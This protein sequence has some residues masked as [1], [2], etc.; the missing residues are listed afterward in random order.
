[1]T[2]VYTVKLIAI[3]FTTLGKF[4][5]IKFNEMTKRNTRKRKI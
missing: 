5:S 1:V 2:I 4:V 3:E